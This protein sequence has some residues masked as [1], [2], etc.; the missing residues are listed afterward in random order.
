M[1]RRL[2]SEFLGTAGLLIVIVGSGIMGETLSQG[3]AAVAILANSLATGAGLYA[4]IQ[5]FGPISGS[6]FNP[7]VSFAEF[8]WKKL[9][10]RE[11]LAYIVAQ[12]LGAIT[13][14]LLTHYIFGLEIFQTSQHDRGDLRFFV[15]EVIAT[16]GLLMVIALSGKRNVET[17]PTAVALYITAAYWCTS[18][19]SF[20][21]PAVTIARSMTN[22]FSGILWTGAPGFIIAQLV[23]ACLALLTVRFLT[24]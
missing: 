17:T 15:S 11:T 21:N 9:S 5:I 18:S 14:V 4:L 23:G 6:H 24:K 3:N 20:A 10:G 2:L 8:L 13:G 12:I 19:T 16:F 1:K 7:A 22:T